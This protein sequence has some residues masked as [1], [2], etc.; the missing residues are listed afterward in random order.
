MTSPALDVPARVGRD[1]GRLYVPKAKDMDFVLNAETIRGIPIVQPARRARKWEI[2][3]ILNQGPYNNCTVVAFEGFLQGEPYKHVTAWSQ[4]TR[5]DWYAAAQRRDGL[6]IPHEG[7]TERAVQDEAIA[8]GVVKEFRWV[9]DE[10][11]AREYLRT[12]G[13]LLAGTDWY[14]TFF[15]PGKHAYVEPQGTPPSM[16][17]EWIVR[18]YYPKTNKRWPD[19]Y[20]CVCSYGEGFGDKGLF[21]MK[22]EVFR[23]LIFQTNGD[24]C[25]P[26]EVARKK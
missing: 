8:R 24:L 12:R 10:D 7:S 6:P 20:E 23:Y 15:D 17:H 18:W 11:T 14:D 4:A 13:M 5:D 21:R 1:T 25:S 26:I 16:G 19:T 22:S 2:G 3:P 9:Q